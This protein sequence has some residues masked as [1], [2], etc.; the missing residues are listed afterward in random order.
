MES[1]SEEMN[2]INFGVEDSNDV[3]VEIADNM[4]SDYES[5]IPMNVVRLRLPDKEITIFPEHLTL[6]HWTR[7]FIQYIKPF[8]ERLKKK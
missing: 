2:M 4:P 6:W 3:E 1:D 5:P 7:I 8:K